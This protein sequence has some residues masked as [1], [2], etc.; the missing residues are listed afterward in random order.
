MPADY[1]VLAP[2]Y[3]KL[4]LSTRTADLIPQ[5][6]SFA[7]V[8]HAWMGRRVL[9]LG[10]GTGAVAYW[11]SRRGLNVTAVDSSAEMITIASQ[12]FETSGMGLMWRQA[13]ARFLNQE[14][15]NTDMVIAL[16]L[17]NDLNSL[18]DLE[19]VIGT[20][21]RVLEPGKMLIF[22]ML[23]V[24][25]LAQLD[26]HN[27]EV[28]SDTIF[29]R[30]RNSP[31]YLRSTAMQSHRGYPVQVVQALLSRT[32]FELIA[33]TDMDLQPFDA[34]NPNGDRVLFVARKPGGTED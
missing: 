3:D 11:L 32:G 30:Q 28:Y 22:D 6:F 25:G 16:D 23:T 1:A 31:Y 9:E 20:S 13:D 5:L 8:T 10:T 2:I 18:K 26:Q 21:F 33:L 12:A 14:F 4:G 17:V 29:Q 7:Q 15:D 24:R 27:A 19:A 34:A